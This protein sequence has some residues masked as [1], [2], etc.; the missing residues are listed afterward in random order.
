MRR[1]MLTLIFDNIT[2]KFEKSQKR[3][4]QSVKKK[5]FFSFLDPRGV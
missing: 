4:I 2:K 1:G 5:F 3:E